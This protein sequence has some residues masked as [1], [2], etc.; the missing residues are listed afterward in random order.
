MENKEAFVKE[1]GELL[2]KYRVEDINALKYERDGNLEIVNIIFCNGTKFTVNVSMDSY[3]AIIR[4]V[5]R[6]LY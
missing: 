5:M 6:K 1:L 4:D 2:H 3:A